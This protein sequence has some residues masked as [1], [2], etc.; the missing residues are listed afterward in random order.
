[1]LDDA[2]ACASVTERYAIHDRS[3]PPAMPPPPAGTGA[4]WCA[5]P[6]CLPRDATHLRLPGHVALETVRRRE[7]TNMAACASGTAR[8]RDARAADMRTRQ[9]RVPAVS[10]AEGAP[11]PSAHMRAGDERRYTAIF[12]AAAMPQ[13][14]TERTHISDVAQIA[15]TRSLQHGDRRY[16]SSN[17]RC[18]IW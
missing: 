11:S 18:P 13:H 16:I 15:V 9:S 8:R 1:M 3:L 4:A 12:A 10:D 2:T 7:E 17:N 14:V 5:V 6:P